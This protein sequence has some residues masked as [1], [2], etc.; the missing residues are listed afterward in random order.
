MEI[1]L[2]NDDLIKICNYIRK[3]NNT[4]K[5]Y[6]INEIIEYFNSTN[7]NG[8]ISIDDNNTIFNHTNIYNF[9]KIKSQALLPP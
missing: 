5:K 2:S 4:D 7:N 8:I 9:S 3:T 6:S 1:V